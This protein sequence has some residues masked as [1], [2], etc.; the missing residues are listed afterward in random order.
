[1]ASP[2]LLI[3]VRIERMCNLA[4]S[5]AL[6]HVFDFLFLWMSYSSLL[7]L[8]CTQTKAVNYPTGKRFI[9]H[10]GMNKKM[11]HSPVSTVYNEPNQN[12][13]VQNMPQRRH[14]KVE[15]KKRMDWTR[16]RSERYSKR[17]KKSS[18]N[19]KQTRIQSNFGSQLKKKTKENESQCNLSQANEEKKP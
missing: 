15:A 16:R 1:M 2:S 14:S 9:W 4:F 13:N 5:N 3:V 11:I 17:I 19:E 6:E 12:Q 10:R 18:R 8:W 7:L